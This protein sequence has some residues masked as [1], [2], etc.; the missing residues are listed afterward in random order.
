MQCGILAHETQVGFTVR[1]RLKNS[2]LPI[3]PLCD[4]VGIPGYNDARHSTHAK[5]IAY[6]RSYAICFGVCPEWHL[7]KPLRIYFDAD[8]P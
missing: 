5:S 4:V 6:N 8:I 2:R 3:A 1:V 7:I